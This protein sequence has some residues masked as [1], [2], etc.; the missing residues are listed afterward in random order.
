MA[1]NLTNYSKLVLSRLVPADPYTPN[2]IRNLR[3]KPQPVRDDLHFAPGHFVTINPPRTLT[4]G[5]CGRWGD[6]KCK[7]HRGI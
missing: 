5:H 3:D 6:D 4:C 1:P 2:V 7:Y